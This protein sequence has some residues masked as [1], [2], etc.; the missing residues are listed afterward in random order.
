MCFIFW[1]FNQARM[2][3]LPI[4][5]SIFFCM[6]RMHT[7]HPFTSRTTRNRK[8]FQ[9]H[10][11]HHDG[12]ELWWDNLRATLEDS[13]LN[14][15]TSSSLNMSCFNC[16]FTLNFIYLWLYRSIMLTTSMDQMLRSLLTS[17]ST[18]PKSWKSFL[19]NCGR[20]IPTIWQV[21]VAL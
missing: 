5:F 13:N 19:H 6:S 21:L 17:T 14:A 4:R 10:F 15:V 12:V 18:W 2:Q 9:M 1:L 20:W 16:A 7:I 11:T 3:R 8:C